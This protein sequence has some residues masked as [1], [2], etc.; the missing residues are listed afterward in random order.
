MAR[1]T[2]NSRSSGCT[3]ICCRR[4]RCFFAA[5]TALAAASPAHD[6]SVASAGGGLVVNSP[7]SHLWLPLLLSLTLR[8]MN[9]YQAP[10]MKKL[11]TDSGRA[12]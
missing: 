11:M 8:S 4:S 12:L 1:E 3:A 9:K 10:A 2:G 5:F 7:L 6:A